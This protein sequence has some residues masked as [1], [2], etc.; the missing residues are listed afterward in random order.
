[1]LGE[2]CQHLV[3]LWEAPCLSLREH[4]VAVDEHVEL[5]CPACLHLGAVRRPVDLGHETRGPLVIARSGGA[6]QDPDV[7]HVRDCSRRE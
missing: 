3:E 2:G 1:V 6:V 4:E 7:R 5:T